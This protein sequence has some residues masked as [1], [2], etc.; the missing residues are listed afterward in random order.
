MIPLLRRDTEL[1]E[2]MDDPDCDPVK[3][4]R[5]YRQFGT[6]NRLVASWDRIL[7]KDVLK[8]VGPPGTFTLLDVGCGLMD[9]ALYLRERAARHGYNLEITG[10]DPAHVVAN[11]LTQ[12]PLPQGC[13]YRMCYL[14]DLVTEGKQFDIVVSNHLLHHLNEDELPGF[15]SEVQQV[16]RGIALMNDLRRNVLSWLGFGLITLPIRWYSF[17]SIDGMR[18]IRRSYRPHELELLLP[19]DARGWQVS[20]IFPY[21]LLVSYRPPEG[22]SRA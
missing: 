15:L 14:S 22:S 3:L 5:T 7:T 1:R 18:S 10:I 16:T 13:T 20:T 9:N 21:R 8:R 12:S 19:P 2:L 6:I 11:M 17:L 4:M